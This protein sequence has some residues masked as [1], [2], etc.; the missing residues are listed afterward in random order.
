M[1]GAD[2]AEARRLMVL[3]QLKPSGVSD[4]R[5]LD[6]M[7]VLPRERFLPPEAAAR[8]YADVAVPLPGGRAMASPL[9]TARLVQLAAVRRDDRAL[10]L[11]AGTGYGAALIAALHA[12]V[13]AVEDD[14]MLLSLA[15][16]ALPAVVAPGAVQLVEAPPR[17]GHAAGAP[18]DV[19]MIEGALP[20]IPRD[21]EEQLAEGG[22]LVTVLA[23]PD[24]SARA[25]LVRRAGHSFTRTPAFDAPSWP[26]PA[27]APRPAFAF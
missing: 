13:V 8:A 2:L 9:T 16:A 4:A 18:Y 15:R 22:R 11:A 10:V 21:I 1:D 23:P 26:A 12:R 6:A 19:I 7:R 3:G 20:A 14:P 5:I 17:A 24:A 25:V 27:F